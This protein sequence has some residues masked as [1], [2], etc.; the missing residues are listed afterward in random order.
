MMRRRVPKWLHTASRH[1]RFCVQGTD[2]LDVKTKPGLLGFSIP[3]K[4]VGLLI[5][6]GL[7]IVNES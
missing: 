1:A 6:T 7:L 2:G 3:G 5:S 4:N